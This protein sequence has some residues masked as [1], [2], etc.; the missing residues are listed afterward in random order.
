MNGLRALSL[1][2]LCVATAHATDD[3]LFTGFNGQP[4]T[5]ES[6]IADGQWLLV[7]FWAHNCHICNQEATSYARFHTAHAD[8][9]ARVLGVSIDGPEH[10]AEAADFIDRHRLP[11]PNLIAE[12]AVAMLYFMSLTGEPFR[13]TPTFLLYAPDGTLTAVQA[14]AV[15]VDSIEAFIAK[16]ATGAAARH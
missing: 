5:I 16:H 8:R 14:G 1:W 12:P 6:H 10:Q 7:M 11:F 13:G 2:V 15:P 4:Q 3:V 9:D